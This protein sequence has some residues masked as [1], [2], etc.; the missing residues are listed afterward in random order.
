MFQHYN[1]QYRT[2]QIN[3]LSDEGRCCDLWKQQPH[4]IFALPISV[5]HAQ[6][7]RTHTST[8]IV[9]YQASYWIFTF[10]IKHSL[11]FWPFSLIQVPSDGLLDQDLDSINKP[12][13]NTLYPRTKG[14]PVKSQIIRPQNW[15]K[16]NETCWN[17][18]WGIPGRHEVS[19]L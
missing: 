3:I 2:S 5:S 11:P 19:F 17:P 7:T 9:F 8:C 15:N 18:K 4:C 14:K 16:A 13:Q 1:L 10:G 12:K 6:N